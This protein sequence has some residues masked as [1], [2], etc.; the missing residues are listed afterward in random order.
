MFRAT[1]INLFYSEC[2]GARFY[3]H[4]KEIKTNQD[5]QFLIAKI[6]AVYNIGY[7]SKM[8]YTYQCEINTVF[9]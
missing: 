5:N 9:E 6:E 4:N 8:Y 2:L 1:R 7:L 3:D